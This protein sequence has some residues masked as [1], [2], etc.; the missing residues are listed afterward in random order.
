MQPYVLGVRE[1]TATSV[2]PLGHRLVSHGYELLVLG[3]PL[4]VVGDERTKGNDLEVLPRRVGQ[5]DRGQT[6]AEA[7]ALAGL[8]HLGVRVGDASV[9]A[10]V[11][12]VADQATAEPKLVTAQLRYVDDFRFR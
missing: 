7:A 11:G 3:M 2:V 12:G 9:A 8:V 10:P 5:R 6:A 1:M 4:D